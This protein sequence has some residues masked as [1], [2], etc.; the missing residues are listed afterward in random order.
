[1]LWDAAWPRTFGPFPLV[2]G[3]SLGPH[4]GSLWPGAELKLSGMEKRTGAPSLVIGEQH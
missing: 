4:S 3:A 1:M 2:V